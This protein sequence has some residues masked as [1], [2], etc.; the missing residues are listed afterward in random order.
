ME[1]I[2]DD[3]F[4]VCKGRSGVGS[5][6]PLSKLHAVAMTSPASSSDS[7]LSQIAGAATSDS[8]VTGVGANADHASHGSKGKRSPVFK[9][10]S[11][12]L[13]ACSSCFS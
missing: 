5:P 1:R 13:F 4:S 10:S 9:T 3:P 2:V 8:T 12:P 11:L 7:S 6:T